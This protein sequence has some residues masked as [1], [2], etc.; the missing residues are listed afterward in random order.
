MTIETRDRGRPDPN[1]ALLDMILPRVSG[2]DIARTMRGD[3]E[4]DG[5]PVILIRAAPPVKERLTEHCRTSL[6]KPFSLT[7]LLDIVQA[8]IGAPDA[9]SPAR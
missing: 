2:E 7:A 6:R 1:R 4:L 8:L 9:N 5:I 3:P